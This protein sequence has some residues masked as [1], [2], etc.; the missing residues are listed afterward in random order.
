MK[1][2]ICKIE[3]FESSL[4]GYAAIIQCSYDFDLKKKKKNLP[5]RTYSKKVVEDNQIIIFWGLNRPISKSYQ[6]YYTYNPSN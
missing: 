6:P 1:K 4:G 2:Y 3:L 5:A